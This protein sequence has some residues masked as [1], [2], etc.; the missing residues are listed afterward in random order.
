MGFDDLIARARG[1]QCLPLHERALCFDWDSDL[2]KLALVL[3]GRAGMT[4]HPWHVRVLAAALARD[5]HGGFVHHTVVVLVPRQQGK[6][7]LA[8]L[9]LA[10]AVYS[11]HVAVVTAQD[12]TRA[13]DF[14]KLYLDKLWLPA[15]GADLKVSSR[16][17]F[18]AARH[19]GRR[20]SIQPMAANDSAPRGKTVDLLVV[21]EA[22]FH[23]LSFL[24]TARPT[25]ATRKLTRQMW[26]LSNAGTPDSA[27]LK[28]LR[29]QGRQG[30]DERIALF[31]WA[32]PED[33][34]PSDPEVWR[35]CMPAFDLDPG[36]DEAF[37]R[38][39]FGINPPDVFDREWLNRWALDDGS[40]VIDLALWGKCATRRPPRGSN[41]VLAVSC[42]IDLQNAAVVAC[43]M[44]GDGKLVTELVKFQEGPS[45]WVVDHVA[46]LCAKW[47]CRAVVDNGPVT[48]H[49]IAEL[50]QKGVK[51]A[52]VGMADYSAGCV[53][54]LE[55]IHEGLLLHN[56]A[57]PLTNAAAVATRRR[58]GKEGRWAWA[59]PARLGGAAPVPVTP[60]EAA[61][62]GAFVVVNEAPVPVPIAYAFTDEELGLDDDE[63]AA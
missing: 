44:S 29:D 52:P 55:R 38:A 30:A 26:A 20:G 34:D 28:H 61:S 59:R 37:V 13:V 14:W 11:G 40:T 27:M 18:E 48:R 60:L 62:A 49:L 4:P 24:G 56:S 39:E 7:L 58:L 21:D 23:S 19:L 17:G 8:A 43:S 32:A 36:V 54:V 50:T 6:S 2:L 16:G 22:W 15:F 31:E 53:L 63:E 47:G 9:R 35:A 12:R 45:L 5:E 42:D 46:G 25:L 51:V 33:A 3:A 41:L 1:L 57:E 10:V